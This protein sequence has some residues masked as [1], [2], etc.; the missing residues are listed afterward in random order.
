MTTPLHYLDQPESSPE[1]LTVGDLTLL[2]K[3]TLDTAF[4]DLWVVGEI[5]N[6]S[7][8]RSG[9]CYL[10]L[11]D[12]TAQ[13]PAVIW[14]SALSRIRFDFAD[15]QLVVCHGRIDVYPP[16]GKYQ[17]VI[18]TLEPLGQ[19]GLERAF[20]QLHA[21]LEAEGLFAPER[22]RPL[23]KPVRRVAVV[24]SPTGAAL[25]D[26]LQVTARRTRRIDVLIVPV[27]VQGDGASTEIAAAMK[28]LNKHFGGHVVPIGGRGQREHC[29]PQ[30]TALPQSSEKP[31]DCIVV[32]RGGGSLEDLWAFNEEPLVRAVAASQIPVV[33]A[34]GHEIDV[35]LCD[36]AADLRALTPS[37]AA[38][39]IAPNDAELAET[40]TAM[41]RFLDRGITQKW[42]LATHGLG[43]FREHPVFTRPV[44]TLIFPTQK[45]LDHL[46]AGL[47]RGV[48]TRLER[49]AAQL[50]NTSAT[51]EALSPLAVLGRGYSLTFDSEN[52]LLSHAADL[53]EGDEITTRFADGTVQS[54][55][56]AVF[57][58][59]ETPS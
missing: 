31:I 43:R 7:R 10:T 13:L 52:K 30:R 6:L 12:E 37:E 18:D 35:T 53:H 19:G 32:T 22:K 46:D 59:Q 15:G 25:R 57:L 47:Q 29:D 4:G 11:K 16:H 48:K 21:K 38:E 20:R 27:R 17:L 2:I 55:V 23:P 1:P 45:T 28:M 42:Q 50:G 33:S 39:R 34:I 26:F 49:V 36:L 44:E 24:T 58:N 41:Q 40:L 54:I 14:R 56:R 9:H 51:L 3:G 5:S 8:P